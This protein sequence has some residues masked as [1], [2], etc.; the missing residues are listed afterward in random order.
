MK[1][2]TYLLTILNRKTTQC[3]H[4]ILIVHL[5]FSLRYLFLFFTYLKG[6]IFT[7][8]TIYGII[9]KHDG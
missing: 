6:N 9:N 8:Y 4:H 2:S 5:L 3:M 7:I 1:M